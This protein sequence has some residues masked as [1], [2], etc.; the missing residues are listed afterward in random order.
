MKSI[1][2]EVLGAINYRAPGI[3]P[4]LGVANT[5]NVGGPQPVQ[6]DRNSQSVVHGFCKNLFSWQQEI[7]SKLMSRK[8]VFVVANPSAGKTMPIMCYWSNNILGLNTVNNNPGVNIINNL[9][10]LLTGTNEQ[11]S[12]IPKT[13]W[14]VPVV[15]L[16]EEVARGFKE[17]FAN[18]LAQAIQLS[19]YRPD[20]PNSVYTTD[21]AE[22]NA[23]QTTITNR[24]E[25]L[26]GLIAGGFRSNNDII[27]NAPVLVA[28]YDSLT[29]LSNNHNILNNVGLF[30]IDE[31]HQMFEYE[32]I[33][34]RDED[35]IKRAAFIISIFKNL[36]GP[37]HCR[38][39]GLTGTLNPTS[40]KEFTDYCNSCFKRRFDDPFTPTGKGAANPAKISI[41]SDNSLKNNNRLIEIIK[42]SV[43]NKDWGKVIL[44]FG[45]N[46]MIKLAVEAVKQ[47]KPFGLS[48]IAQRSQNTYGNPLSNFNNMSNTP[49]PKVS[50]EFIK[51]IN[52]IPEITQIESPLLRE[53][54]SRGFAFH[55]RGKADN[56]T[57]L[58]MND[59]SIVEYLFKNKKI[60]VLLASDTIGIGVNLDIKDIYI[61]EVEKSYGGPKQV[62]NLAD[63]SQ[64]LNRVGRAN[65][66]IAAIHTPEENVLTVSNAI[67]AIPSNYDL[68][69]MI[70]KLP[71]ASVCNPENLNR[72]V[73]NMIRS[74]SYNE[75]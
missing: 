26:V 72:I 58:S 9:N 63:L 48:D 2:E 64:V 15:S 59:K 53:C 52:K 75:K 66:P 23:N 62:I 22:I 4:A 21:Q 50:Q 6:F 73:N 35:K 14:A 43:F 18:F 57:E 36:P 28:T 68:I 69:P 11:L 41:L 38:V 74:V 46:K 42:T 13:I 1:L 5:P 27:R 39:V 54:I 60:S 31:A 24:I 44:L 55:F 25:N 12:R 71:H 16:A 10:T 61:P 67:T 65:V 30:V 8:D 17:Y 40:A 34:S 37:D 3:F 20:M 47:I 19:S 45:T 29:L 51:N 33:K 49:S 32:N 70:D 56:L 7:V